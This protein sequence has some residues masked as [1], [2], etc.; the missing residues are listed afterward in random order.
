[1]GLA[2]WGRRAALALLGVTALAAN[3]Q[4]EAQD[5]WSS[6]LAAARADLSLRD[7]WLSL[8]AKEPLDYERQVAANSWAFEL[9]QS[10]DLATAAEVQSVLHQRL[11]A[12][13]TVTNLATTLTRLGR[14][15]DTRALLYDYLERYPRS[16]SGWNYLGQA[17]LGAGQLSAARAAWARAVVCG[18]DGATVSLARL[19]LD[20]G[21][22]ESARAGFRVG[23]DREPPGAWSLRGWGLTCLPDALRP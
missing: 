19:A 5:D 1:M 17:E 18:S 16:G 14:L 15:E 12:E 9:A 23:A 3:P 13:W 20:A 7:T 11:D 10:G 21:Q 4:E 6:A 2:H 22:I 8:L